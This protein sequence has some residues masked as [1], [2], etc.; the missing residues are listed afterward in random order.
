MP[1]RLIKE[2]NPVNEECKVSLPLVVVGSGLFTGFLP[3]AQGTFGSVIGL[4]IF[5]IPGFSN[6]SV[7]SIAIVVAFIFGVFV[8]ERMR[9]RYGEDPPQVTIDEI[10][11]LWFT[12]FI[13]FIMFE[14]FF[15]AK[16]F[17]PTFNFSTKLL[18]AVVGFFMFR[19]FDI[20][21]LQPAKYFDEVKSGYGIM[22]DDIF[23]GLYAGI[24]SSVVTHFFWYRIIV[25]IFH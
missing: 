16:A 20:I 8:S 11:G 1:F 18:F 23:S 5:L 10:A 25:K 9:G 13:G 12:Y 4:L 22:I 6:F 21:K 15:Q 2:K 3:A 14:L 7:L 17:G 19:F 24:I